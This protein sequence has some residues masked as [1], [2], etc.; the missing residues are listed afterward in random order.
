MWIISKSHR[1]FFFLY[2]FAIHS[3]SRHEKLCQMSV[4]LFSLFRGSIYQQWLIIKMFCRAACEKPNDP[5]DPCIC[6]NI[7]VAID[8]EDNGKFLNSDAFFLLHQC[9][10]LVLD[11]SKPFWT[12]SKMAFDFWLVSKMFENINLAQASGLSEGL[13]IRGCQYHLVGIICLSWLR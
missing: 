3:S 10:K 7:A 12:G 1:E 6:D 8:I 11:G 2:I 5:T 13:K 9:P 4:R